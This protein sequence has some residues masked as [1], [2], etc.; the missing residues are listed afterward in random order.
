MLSSVENEGSYTNVLST[1][2]ILQLTSFCT[3]GPR[4]IAFVFSAQL[5]SNG[6]H[7]GIRSMKTRQVLPGCAWIL[8][9]RGTPKEH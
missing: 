2:A 5:T 8:P 9:A 7:F 1:D 3:F 4:C 6:R